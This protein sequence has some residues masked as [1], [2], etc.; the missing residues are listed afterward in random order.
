MT[1]RRV[2]RLRAC[3]GG[4]GGAFAETRRFCTRARRCPFADRPAAFRRDFS[5]L[6]PDAF[7]RDFSPADPTAFRRDLEPALPTAFRP[8]ALTFSPTLS[9]NLRA[10]SAELPVRISLKGSRAVVKT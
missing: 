9:P 7:R 6:D 1:R 8:A 5:P 3:C 10:R 4:G 2:A